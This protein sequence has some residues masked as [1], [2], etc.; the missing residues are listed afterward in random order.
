MMSISQ[1]K[2]ISIQRTF[3][4]VKNEDYLLLLPLQENPRL[5]S[6]MNQ[7][8]AWTHLPVG[9]FGIYL[10]LTKATESLSSQL[11]LWTRLIS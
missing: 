9:T 4:E 5:L 8:Q 10:K 2:E 6:L 11:T 1:K 3:Q 7:H